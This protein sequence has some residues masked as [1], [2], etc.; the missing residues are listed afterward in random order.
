[1]NSQVDSL[2]K[3]RCSLVLLVYFEC[4]IGCKLIFNVLCDIVS[5]LI[6]FVIL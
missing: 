4:F 6:M 5:A 2:L 3:L 1:M